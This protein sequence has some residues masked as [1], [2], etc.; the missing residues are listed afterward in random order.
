M[1]D[2]SRLAGVVTMAELA[3]LGTS[4]GQVQRL[5]RRG[6]L[7]RLVRGGYAPAALAAA[8][9]GDRAWEHA[10]LVAA[11]LAVTGPGAVVSHRSAALLHG[12]DLLGRE[13]GRTVTLTRPPDSTSSRTGRP[14][15]R[16]HAA[17]LPA[18]HVVTRHGMP[19]TS[20]AR[21]VIDL[22]R[23][24]PFLAGVVVA[25]SALRAGQ[26]TKPEL[27][28]VITA[29]AHWRGIRTARQVAAFS[30]ARSESV[31][32]SISRVAFRAYGLPPPELQVWVGDETE[33]IGRADFLWRACRTI[34]EADGA[35]KYAD[36]SRAMA[37][38]ERDASLRR[39]GFEVVHFTW[40]DITRTPGDVAA[41]IRAAF[42]RANLLNREGL[43]VRSGDGLRT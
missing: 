4:P 43:R 25:D 19:V 42:Q 37:Q 22:A 39:A 13:T 2:T 27:Q 7:L 12:F 21:T 40:R 1:P 28:S 36:P 24:C 30:D 29:C 31:L 34:A 9:S 23:T 33:M 20:A 35:L 18:G 15:A 11:V 10:V 8:G 14:G 26:T 16:L 3:A 41:S 32:E 5:V 38:L 6:V 17:T